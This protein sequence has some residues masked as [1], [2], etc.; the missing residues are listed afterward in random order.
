MLL[1]R[2]KMSVKLTLPR[3]GVAVILLCSAIVAEKVKLRVN[4]LGVASTEVTEGWC[5]LSYGSFAGESVAEVRWRPRRHDPDLSIYRP[6]RNVSLMPFHAVFLS[7]GDWE[8]GVPVWVIIA[9]IVL[10]VFVK[11]KWVPS[12]LPVKI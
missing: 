10:R 2:L 1:K 6:M 9:A 7:R 5:L 12:A 3:V 4:T 8:F 11:V